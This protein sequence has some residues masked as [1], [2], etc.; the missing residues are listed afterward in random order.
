MP[1]LSDRNV[2]DNWVRLGS[3]DMREMA[4]EKASRILAD[5]HVKPL[6]KEQEEEIVRILSRAKRFS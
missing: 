3:K 1:E 4:R 5:H 6:E 2:Y